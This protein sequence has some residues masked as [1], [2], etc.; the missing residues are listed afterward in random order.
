MN[1]EITQYGM[2][3]PARKVAATSKQ[4]FKDEISPKSYEVLSISI[5]IIDLACIEP[6][7]NVLGI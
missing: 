6:L 4:R 2:P 7:P 3:A 1:A 5:A